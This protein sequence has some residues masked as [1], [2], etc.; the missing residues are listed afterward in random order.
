VNCRQAEDLI[1]DYLYGELSPESTESFRRHLD[2]CPECAARVSELSLVRRTAAALNRVEPSRMTVNRVL[3]LAREEAESW[4]S[5]WGWGWLKILAPL[6]LMAVVGGLVLFQLRT[7]L[8]SQEAIPPGFKKDS[9]KALS[10]ANSKEKSMET[11]ARSSE[12]AVSPRNLTA[13]TNNSPPDSN[14]APSPAFH[15]SADSDLMIAEVSEPSVSSVPPKNENRDRVGTQI[16]TAP[17]AGSS[18]PVRAAESFSAD[19]SASTTGRPSPEKQRE[20]A[21]FSFSAFIYFEDN[22]LNASRPTTDQ[23]EAKAE[24]AADRSAGSSGTSMLEHA[25]KPISLDS[26]EKAFKEKYYDQA[27]IMYSRIL[28]TLP[29]EHPDRPQALCGLAQAHEALGHSDKALR[30]YQALVS[31]PPPYREMAQRK[32]KE[33]G[34]PVD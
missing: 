3:A 23:T 17:G 10:A 24:M 33:L 18:P 12:R 29:A 25:E 21:G 20:Q 8:V 7:G 2:G 19:R 27:A 34:R 9:F 15:S 11:T 14:P 1:I 28:E 4:R 32:V 16:E 26:A 31:A 22:H 30:V 5:V 13:M 6:C